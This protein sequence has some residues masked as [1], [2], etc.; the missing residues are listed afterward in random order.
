M[1]VGKYKK[2]TVVKFLIVV[3]LAII[4]T[5]I[6]VIYCFSKDNTTTKSIVGKNPIHATKSAIPYQEPLTVV[7][8]DEEEQ[9]KT[10]TQ[11][12]VKVEPK[13]ITKEEIKKQEITKIEE[14][15][16]PI[17]SFTQKETEETVTAVEVEKKDEMPIQEIQTKTEAEVE[18]KYQRFSTIGRIEIPQTGV[19]LPILEQVTVEGM[20]K[21]PCLLYA[22]GELNQSGNNLIVGHNFRNGTIFSNNKNLTLGDKIYI[23]SLDGKK[24]EYT[25]YRKFITTAEDVSYIKRDT[26]GKPEITLSSCTDDDELRII[27]LA[28]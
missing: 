20:K 6:I 24:I 14:K 10:E 23:T 1:M 17:I 9:E 21:A 22:T 13:T 7:L 5:M 16:E 18:A 28:K 15:K 4:C 25:I 19:D 8:E 26:K 27:I 12:A 11:E 3:V 2:E